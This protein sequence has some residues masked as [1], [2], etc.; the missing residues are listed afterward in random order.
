MAARPL[1]ELSDAAAQRVRKLV[2]NA[3]GKAIGLRIGVKNGGCAGMSYTVELADEA[4]PGESVVE[5]KGALVLIDPKAVLFLIGATMDFTVSKMSATFTF[6][7]PN[8]TASCGC[9]E[10]VT[11]APAAPEAMR[12]FSA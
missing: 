3:G 5:D 4:R 10:S 8:E 1:M 7:N 6:Q 2:E 9:G 11:L 12:E